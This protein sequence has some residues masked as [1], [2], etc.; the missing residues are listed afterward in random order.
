MSGMATDIVANQ[1]EKNCQED[2]KILMEESSNKKVKEET[3][4]TGERE[5]RC[6]S[7]VRQGHRCCRDSK[8]PKA[9]GDMSQG[10]RF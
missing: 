10:G 9:L 7:D 3:K 6:C 8:E 1:L 4:E 5:C 2:L